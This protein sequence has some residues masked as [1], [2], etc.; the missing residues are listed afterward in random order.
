MGQS[1]ILAASKLRETW[2]YRLRFGRSGVWFILFE[3]I[4]VVMIIFW[5]N[6]A[7]PK[8]GA[9]LAL[10]GILGF[11]VAMNLLMGFGNGYNRAGGMLFRDEARLDRLLARPRDVVLSAFM[12]TYLDILRPTM[13]APL[14]LALVLAYSWFPGQVFLLVGLAFILPLFAA[15]LAVMLIKRF[16][17]GIS[18]LLFIVAALIVL[19][20][21]AGAI[22]LAV[23]LAKGRVFGAVWLKLSV[24]Q[25]VNWWLL[26]FL[27]AGLIIIYIERGLA[28]L[29]GEALLLQEEQTIRFKNDQAWWVMSFLSALHLPSVVQA[30][31]LKEWLSL[32]RNSLTKFRLIFWLILSVV[33]FSHPGVRTFVGTLPSPLITAYVIWVFCFGEMIATSYQS[34]A[35]RLGVLW[36]AAVKPGQLALG[37]FLAY[38]P[39]VLFA[40]GTAGIVVIAAGHQGASVLFVLLFT[41]V[42]AA[43]GIAFSLAPA[44]AA[45]NKVFYHSGSISDMA[46][47]QVPIALPGMLSFIAL[48]GFLAA[49]C[50]IIILIQSSGAISLASVGGVF[51]GSV[52]LAVLMIA[53]TSSLLKWCYRL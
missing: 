25:P 14:L 15:V 46:L 20:G 37:K 18:G 42:G 39:L 53:A 31:M 49:Y 4:G 44:A 48:I 52:L 29:W 35:D 9:S 13:Q 28:Y 5:L 16:M 36:L 3:V 45:M 32:Q 6:T 2:N 21:M 43:A 40:L 24:F 38:L 12:V 33:P 26:I 19:T 51:A 22:W 17:S 47:E 34:E 10:P 11:L 1:W 23:N 30:V 41:F 27:V 50:Y 8:Q 7:L